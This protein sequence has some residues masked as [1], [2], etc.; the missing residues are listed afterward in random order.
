MTTSPGV[1]PQ[2]T[3]VDE[4]IEQRGC[5]DTA[6][7]GTSSVRLESACTGASEQAAA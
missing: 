4:W 2:V 6:V 1:A 7:D 5:R 3:V